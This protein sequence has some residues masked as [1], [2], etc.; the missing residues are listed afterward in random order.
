MKEEQRKNDE[1]NERRKRLHEKL[2]KKE[3]ENYQKNPTKLTSLPSTGLIVNNSGPQS[4]MVLP[5]HHST[6]DNPVIF[7]DPKV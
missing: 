6:L 3:N 4:Q 5:N 1:K 2:Q 7:L